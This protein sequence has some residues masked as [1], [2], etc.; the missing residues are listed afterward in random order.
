MQTRQFPD[1][2]TRYSEFIGVG[3]ISPE[4]MRRIDRNA[5]SLGISGL[6]L[7]ESA[8]S[9]LSMVARGYHAKTILILCGS[10]NNGGDGMVAARHLAGEAE[11]FVLWYDSKNLTPLAACQAERMKNCSVHKIRF[12]CR[13]EVSSHASLFSRADLIIDAL[14]GTG[15]RGTVREPIRTCIELANQTPAPI[16]SVDLPSPGI[17]P[18]KVCAFHRAKTEGAE[19]YEIGIPILA[20]IATG[21]GDLLLMHDRKRDAHKGAGGE[22]LVIG[23]GPY[24]GAPWLSGLAALRAGA[25]IVRIVTPHYLPEPD[26]IH[27]PVMGN[28]ISTPDLDTI[29][30]LCERSD[31]VLSGPGLGTRS[32]DVITAIASHIKKGVFDADSLKNPLPQAEESLFTPHAGEFERITGIKPEATPR[33]RAQSIKQA[34]LPGTVL[35]KGPVDVVSDGTKVRFNLTGTPAMTTGGTGD[36]LAGVCAALMVDLPAFEAACI[37]AYVTG[38][39]GEQITGIYGCGMTARDLLTA[40]PQVLFGRTSEGE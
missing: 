2:L 40:I 33:V 20:E 13:E 29:I 34:G 1:D 23:G 19:V 17:M 26:L 10:G 31:V 25:D 32:H 35:L 11:V 9:A 12:R 16:L 15:G 5:Q 7:M 38:R 27:I 4:E 18:D 22:V 6:E 30:P 21:P 8:G 28:S 37:G 3:L 39:A 36:V 24:Q 14:L